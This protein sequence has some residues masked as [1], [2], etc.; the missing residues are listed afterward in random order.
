[1]SLAPPRGEGILHTTVTSSVWVKEVCRQPEMKNNRRASWSGSVSLQIEET[2]VITAICRQREGLCECVK[3][4][5]I[6][7]YLALFRV[8]WIWEWNLVFNW[9]IYCHFLK[10][11]MLFTLP[12]FEKQVTGLTLAVRRGGSFYEKHF[13]AS[14]NQLTL[15]FSCEEEIKLPLPS[16]SY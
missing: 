11:Y 15:R 4:A 3:S 16:Y 5:F 6:N 2:L 9:F 8:H 14:A 10:S 13:M 7:V 12:D 1:M